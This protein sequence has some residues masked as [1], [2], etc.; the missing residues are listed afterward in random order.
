MHKII[1]TGKVKIIIKME[2]I[3]NKSPKHDAEALM[4]WENQ[5]KISFFKENNFISG[6]KS[7]DFE[8]DMSQV[9]NSDDNIS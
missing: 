4:R 9:Q 8:P 5:I 3:H 7:S 2:K 6:E 1:D